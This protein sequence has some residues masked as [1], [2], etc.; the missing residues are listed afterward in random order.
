MLLQPA[1]TQHG[2]S[3]YAYRD[4]F[5]TAPY[6]ENNLQIAHLVILPKPAGIK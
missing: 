4:T 6:T 5:W 3:Q 1:V 2:L